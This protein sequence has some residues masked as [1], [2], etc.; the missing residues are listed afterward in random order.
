MSVSTPNSDATSGD[1]VVFTTGSIWRS[2]GLELPSQARADEVLSVA[3]DKCTPLVGDME[4]GVF[5]SKDRSGAVL[6]FD[7]VD[8]KIR[9]IHEDF[10]GAA[11]VSARWVEMA[12][13]FALADLLGADGQSVGQ[14]CVALRSGLFNQPG[15]G[16]EGSLSLVALTQ[17]AELYDGP[18]SYAQSETAATFATTG[19]APHEVKT[20]ATPNPTPAGAETS[21][22]PREFGAKTPADT[23]PTFISM[24]A[25]SVIGQQGAHA[26]AV[27]AGKI[28]AA[29]LHSNTLTG[30]NF[31][32]ME[33]NV[34][35]PLT[36]CTG[37]ADLPGRPRAGQVIAGEFLVLAAD[38]ALPKQR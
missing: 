1:S 2:I 21:G 16:G 31:W 3:A 32:V 11:R 18:M 25:I 12:D 6:V 9:D 27:L 4:T 10:D 19:L 17:R 29:E 35:F 37:E 34:G 20:N 22:K 13:R 8:K 38:T 14:A 33:T 5:T 23:L 30:Q 24:G 15:R 28:T 7:V 36:I 26:G